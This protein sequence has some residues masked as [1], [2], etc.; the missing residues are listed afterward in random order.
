MKILLI[1]AGR[2]TFQGALWGKYDFDFP[3]NVGYVAAYLEKFG[4]I[5]DVIDLQFPDIVLLKEIKRYDLS[6]FDF[7]GISSNLTSYKSAYSSAKILRAAHF[8]KNIFLFG[9]LALYL[10][11]H[12]LKD[13]QEIDFVIFGEEETTVIDLVENIHSPEKTPGICFRKNCEI[14]K[15]EDRAYLEN[16]DILPFPARHKFNVKKYFPTPGKYYIL[17]QITMLSSRGCNYHCLF[18]EKTGGDRLRSRTAENIMNEID[19]VV[20]KYNA[21]EICFLDEM[22]G[23]NKEE[24][25]KLGELILKQNYKIYIRISTRIDYLNKEVLSLLKRAGLYSVGAG[26]ESGSDEILKYNNKKITKNLVREKVKMLKDL[27]LEIRG[28]FMLNLPGEDKRTI[29]ETK[30]FIKELNL[31]LINIQIA[32]PFIGTSFRKL[33]ESDDRYKIIESKWNEWEY[34]DGDDVVFTQSDL[35]EEY[36]LKEYKNIIRNN[37]L[38]LRFILKWIKRIKTYHDFKYSFLQFL[39]LAFKKE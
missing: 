39:N 36:I 11:E 12:I 4:H 10:K 18:C 5:V 22:F 27:E 25:L 14:I 1:S 23:S 34:S 15:T 16:L 32:Y 37:F 35:T 7:I 13:C 31:D 38:N 2:T 24:T 9:P 8:K 6:E 20:K 30:N 28:Y 19:E 3:L 33:V 21:R 29:E 17:P 26:I